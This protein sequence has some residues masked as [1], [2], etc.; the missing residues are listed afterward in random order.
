MKSNIRILMGKAKQIFINRSLM[1]KLIVTYIAVIGIPTI[2]FSIYTF[3]SL[4]NNAKKDAINKHNYE[5]NVECDTIEKNIYIM[6][7]I[8]N[9]ITNN[10]E[11]LEYVDNEKGIDVKELIDFNDTVYKQLINLQNNNPTIKQINIFT[12]NSQVDELWPLIYRE[13][14]I[15]NNDWYKQTLEKSGGEYWNISHYDNDIKIN[16]TT[17][18]QNKNLVVS[19][20]KEIK[21]PLQKNTGIIRIT[22]VSKDFFPNM[23]NLDKLNNGQILLFNTEKN[24]L[25]TNEDNP[26]LKSLNFDREE[27]KLFI[28]DKLRSNKGELS[29]KQ[30]NENYYL[31]YK[32]SPMVNNYLISVIPLNNITQGIAD[33]RRVLFLGGTLLL[34]LLSI[35]IYFVTKA[36]LKRLYIIL[37]CVKQVRTGDL[38]ADIPVYGT[39][40]IGILAHNFRQMMKKIDKLMKENIQKEMISKET[41]LKALKSQIDAHFLFNTLENIR[42]MAQIEENYLVA[43]TLVSLGDMMRYN[44]KWDNDFVSINEEI[45]HIKN[46]VALMTLRYDYQVILH[47][48]IGPEYINKEILKLTIQPL[49]ENA[50]KH[51]LSKKLRSEDGNIYIFIETEENYLYLNVMD[52]GKGMDGNEIQEL[53]EHINGD[54]NVNRR[55][56]LGLKNVNDRIKLF[57]GETC[58]IV[59][60]SQKGSCTKLKLKLTK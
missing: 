58:G 26:L 31:T 2:I 37:N 48:N 8:I 60:E 21:Y 32:E 29:Y 6:R 54:T 28:K 46:Y 38:S 18:E 39:D 49:V 41:E 7:N 20:N 22:M 53:Q 56:G 3:R 44:M 43:D 23:F 59:L 4:D 13:N 36:I 30:G 47:V 14:R 52:D 24:H 17:N 25:K 57:Y 50:I 45:K 51:G 35:I 27:F 55:F 33:S 10:K 16:S 1:K 34:I 11:V 42:V 9:A 40:E 19:L 5:L 15:V 12:H